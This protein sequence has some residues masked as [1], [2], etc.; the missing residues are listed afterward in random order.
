MPLLDTGS[1]TTLI[2]Q[3]LAEELQLEG[4]PKEVQFGTF[5]GNTPKLDVNMVNFEVTPLYDSRTYE[6]K[7]AYAVPRLEVPNPRVNWDELKRHWS[8][9]S[10][11]EF[12]TIVSNKVTVLIGQD[13]DVHEPLDIKRPPKG[14]KGPAAVQTPFGWCVMGKTTWEK[15]YDLNY[16]N[17]TS[18]EDENSTEQLVKGFWTTEIPRK[19]DH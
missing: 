17:F 15:L 13:V 3:D 6:V 4:T 10:E 12:P 18:K 5:D 8:H 2:R 14:T 19:C 7:G 9:L 16:V 1:D 11:L